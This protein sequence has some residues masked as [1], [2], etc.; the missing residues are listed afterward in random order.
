MQII[1]CIPQVAILYVNSYGV[2]TLLF[3]RFSVFHYRNEYRK[4]ANQKFLTKKVPLHFVQALLLQITKI[5]K[6]NVH[7]NEIVLFFNTIS[8]NN[9]VVIT[10]TA[11]STK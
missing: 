6:Y 8:S 10:H 7:C 2:L 4:I 11:S 9:T 1:I 3:S 5:V